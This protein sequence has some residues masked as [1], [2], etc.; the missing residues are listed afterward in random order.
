MERKYQFRPSAVD[1]I[2]PDATSAVLSA[3][4]SGIGRRCYAGEKHGLSCAPDTAVDADVARVYTVEDVVP[5]P[6]GDDHPVALVNMPAA[7]T[8]SG[9]AGQPPTI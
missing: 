3:A 8:A 9:A 5:S 4:R 6:A 7:G 2:G 1:E